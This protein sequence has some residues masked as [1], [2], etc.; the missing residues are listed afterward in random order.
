MIARAGLGIAP[1]LADFLEREAL[2]GTGVTPD[3]FWSGVAAIF[4]R[5]T[6]QNRALLAT[7]DRMQAAIDA[8]HRDHAF[9]PAAYEAFLRE[10]GYLLPEPG[11]FAVDPANVDPEIAERAG[12]QLV[13]PILN[14]RFLLNA[15]NARWGSLYDALYGTDA[16]PGE[17]AS[18]GYDAARGSKVIAWAKAFLDEAVPLADGRWADWTGGT[19]AL[20]DPGQW[21]GNAGDTLLFRHNGLHIEVVVDRGHPIGRDDPAGIADVVLESALTTICDL[22]DSVAAVDAEDKVAGY[23]NWLGLM[24]GDLTASFDKGGRTVSRTLAEDRTYSAPDGGTITLPG[25]SL[26]FVR[27]VGHLMTTPAVRLP[28]GGEAPEGILDAIVTS[29][30]GL[31]DV[32]GPSRNSRAGSIYIVKPKMHGPDE[33][34]L[35]N[36]LFDAVEDLLGLDRHTIKV[37]LMDEERRTSANLAA[38]IYAVRHRL[39]F[40]NTGF[41]DRTGDEMH[42]S[43]H[44]GPMIPK[45]EM[46]ASRWIAAYE[47]RNVQI[48]LACGLSGKAQ[49]G[50]GMWAAP[51]RMADMLDQKIGHPQTGANTAWVPSPTAATLHATHYHRVDVFARQRERA[52]E[53]V[54]PLR[55]LLT[56]PV[57]EAGRNWTPDE[58]RAE[59]D[60][61]AQGILGYVVRWIDQ[62]IGCSKVPDIHDIGLM[63]DRATL[64]ISSQHMANWLLHGVATPAEVD[65]AFTRMAAKV[66]A[67]NA[68]DPLY[69]PMSGHPDSLAWQAAR[70]LVFEGVELPNGYTEPLLHRYRAEAKAAG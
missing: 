66:D 19:P 64:R 49:I 52:A 41:L 25:R 61:N 26:L 21:V 45:G 9:E 7:R 31:H 62:G 51:D 53:P 13:V 15:A 56:I 30:I 5:F 22:E 42:T 67:Q 35:T 68:D 28:D 2:P 60:N 50:K 24:R 58:V 12:P 55:D 3:A 38:C 69:R 40:I 57:A 33:A 1:E 14:A 70:A 29:L 47:N 18:G 10:I 59:L 37:G 17:A 43:M 44:A 8:W 27:N 11:P 65:A 32:R 34:A 48:G 63:E 39:V 4:D 54:A 36:A 6:P 46:K 23:A 16:L 20:A